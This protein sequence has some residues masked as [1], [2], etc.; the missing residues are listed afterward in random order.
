[1]NRKQDLGLYLIYAEIELFLFQGPAS[2][3]HTTCTWFL[4]CNSSRS[5]IKNIQFFLQVKGVRTSM[6]YLPVVPRAPLQ[7][8]VLPGLLCHPILGMGELS[9]KVEV[10]WTLLLLRLGPAWKLL[11]WMVSRQ[12]RMIT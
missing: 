7:V 9:L 5:I 11:L 2:K 4:S 8:T 12:V 6:K 3:L 1:M 10:V